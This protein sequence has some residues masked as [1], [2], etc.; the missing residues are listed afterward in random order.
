V[1]VDGRWYQLEDAERE[2]AGTNV[3]L[4]LK[5]ATTTTA[6]RLHRRRGAARDRQEVLGLRRVPDPAQGRGAELHEGHL[7]TAEGGSGEDEY[8]EFYKHLTH[9]WNDPLEHVLVHVEGTVEARALALRPVEGA[10]RFFMREGERRVQLYV[11]RVFIMDDWEALAA[12]LAALRARRV[13]SDDLSLNVSRE[14]SRRTG[15]SRPSASTW[16]P[17]AG[18]LKDMKEHAP[19]STASSGRSSAPCSGGC[20][21]STRTRTGSRAGA[22]GVHVVLGADRAGLAGRLRRA[23]EG[24]QEAIYYMTASTRARPSARPPGGVPGQGLR[25]PVLHRP[26]DELLAAPGPGVPGQEARVGGRGGLL[27][28]GE[29]RGGQAREELRKEQEESWRPLLDSLR[30]RLQ[31]FVK[32]VRLSSRLTESPAC[33]VGEAGDLSPH[34][35]EL[36][37]APARSRR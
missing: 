28:G 32:D 30:A 17:A 2:T 26:V 34:L 16:P 29:R 31:D 7:G 25:G 1:G 37:S 22:G 21:A 12:A 10:L 5:P 4:H 14:S 33:L 27:G 13:A 19:R 24:G 6:A 18:P 11:K 8:R 36:F 15:R 9:D 20:W 23:H 35:R 3:T